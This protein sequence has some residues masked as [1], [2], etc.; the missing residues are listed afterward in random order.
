MSSRVS[1]ASKGGEI[2]KAATV[3]FL[4]LEIA[5][6]NESEFK[7][8]MY[9][10]SVLLL[11]LSLLDQ[12]IG[13]ISMKLPLPLLVPGDNLEKCLFRPLKVKISG[14]KNH[15]IKVKI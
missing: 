4:T 11:P 3:C 15:K 7:S 14:G 5:Q 12:K 10:V 13:P 2:C 8:L 9:E 6:V 1:P